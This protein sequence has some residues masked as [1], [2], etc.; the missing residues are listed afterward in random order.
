M[1]AVIMSE[2][3]CHHCLSNSALRNKGELDLLSHQIFNYCCAG[4][5]T[6]T[7]TY[8]GLLVTLFLQKIIRKQTFLYIFFLLFIINRLR[9][10]KK[11]DV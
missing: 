3:S 5:Y 1:P 8:L 6:Y 2:T 11:V 9:D 10:T 7:I 4:K